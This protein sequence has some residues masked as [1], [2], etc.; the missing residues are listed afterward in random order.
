[1]EKEKKEMDK[2]TTAILNL[3]GFSHAE[4]PT[5]IKED[6]LRQAGERADS[7]AV[8][9]VRKLDVSKLNESIMDAVK[10]LF[11]EAE[12]DEAIKLADNPVVKK[13][14]IATASI[15]KAVSDIIGSE[16]SRL[17][18]ETSSGFSSS[19]AAGPKEGEKPSG[20]VAGDKV[21]IGKHDAV[22]DEDD[23]WCPRMDKYIGKIATIK[24]VLGFDPE[25]YEVAR[26][27]LDEGEYSWRTRNM[28]RATTETSKAEFN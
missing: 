15:N 21:R 7:T 12:L 8:A 10:T 20:L 23:N 18:S 6:L 26:I 5:R 17:M 3:I 19:H 28:T 16:A 11:T 25:G 24:K 9:L 4:D 2:R 13:A 1:M 22:N 14:R 27:D